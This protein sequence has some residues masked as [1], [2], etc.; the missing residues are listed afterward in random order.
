MPGSKKKFVA[1]GLLAAGSAAVVAAY[2]MRRHKD[3]VVDKELAGL[4]DEADAQ[5]TGQS[6]P[7]V[8]APALGGARSNLKD[9]MG[10]QPAVE[11]KSGPAFPA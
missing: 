5:P 7:K 4:L 10:A 11:A 1:A 8:E 9:L 3:K 2:A 6:S